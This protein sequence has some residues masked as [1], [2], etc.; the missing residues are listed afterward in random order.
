MLWFLLQKHKYFK[1]NPVRI[2]RSRK[3][4]FKL[5]EISEKING[6]PVV[7]VGRGSKWGNPFRVVKY[8][9]GGYG[10]KSDGSD[11]CNKIVIENCK[12]IY[13]DEFQATKDALMCYELWLLPYKHQG[14]TAEFYQSMAMVESIV[15]ELKGKNLACWCEI[16]KKDKLLSAWNYTRCH[17]DILLTYANDIDMSK[18]INDN[19]VAK[20]KL[21]NI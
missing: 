3:K 11:I 21:D 14:S 13:Y 12:G 4:G 8:S 7:Y 10:I 9:N 6:L 15:L 16:A 20:E 5:K 17:A 1:M 19:I 2:K 18:I